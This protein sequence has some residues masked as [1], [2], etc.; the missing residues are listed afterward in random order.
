M[1]AQMAIEL[2]YKSHVEKHK[3]VKSLGMLRG[4][5]HPF[6]KKGFMSS[7]PEGL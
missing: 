7:E 1:L 5:C 6:I 4:H 2:V 3:I